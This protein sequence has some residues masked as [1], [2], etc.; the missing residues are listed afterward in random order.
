MINQY[1]AIKIVD[2]TP[3]RKRL[4]G[5]NRQR[6]LPGRT[7]GGNFMNESEIRKE[8]AI[9]K[10]VNHPN[11][12]R[13]KEII[14]DP[15]S[16]KLF[17]ILEYCEG[18]EVHWTE[19]DGSPALTLLETRRIF[20][21]TLL[22]LEYLH[23]QGI[24]HRDIKPSNLLWAADG[25]VKISDF[26][27]SHYSEALR[28]AATQAGPEGESWVDDVELAKTAGSPAFFAP[29]MCYSGSDQDDAA[30]HARSP[31]GTPVHELTNFTTQLPTANEQHPKTSRSDPAVLS[32]SSRRTFPFKPTQSNES[33]LSR[34]PQSMRSHSSSTIVHRDRMPIT[35]AIDVWALGVTLYCLAFGKTPFDAP[36]EYLLMQVIPT[37]DFHVPP[38]MSKDRLPTGKGNEDANEEALECLDLLRRLLEKDPARRISLDQAKR[39]P[40]TLRGLSDP[41][42]WLASTDPHVQSFVTVS[43][44]EVAAVVIKANRFRDRLRKGLKTISSRLS[45]FGSNSRGRSHSIGDG[46]TNSSY[47]QPVSNLP[48]AIPSQ[49]NLQNAND[50]GR[51]DQALTPRELSPMPSP[52]PMGSLSRRL[53]LLGSRHYDA[54]PS[55]RRRTLQLASP[56][57]TAHLSPTYAVEPIGRSLSSQSTQS[58]SRG[59]I[60]HRPIRNASQSNIRPDTV[61][62]HTASGERSA[63]SPKPMGSSGSLDKLQGTGELTPGDPLRR[64]Q[65]DIDVA[66]RHRS[67][68]N[69]S[70]NGLGLG[71]LAR[72]LSRGSSQRRRPTHTKESSEPSLQSTQG[73]GLPAIE[74]PPIMTLGE[75]GRQ[76][77]FET[78][79]SS[80]YSSG[81]GLSASPERS[82]MISAGPQRRRSTVSEVLT[83]S[84][85][86]DFDWAGSIPDD[87]DDDELEPASRSQSE[88]VTFGRR[89]VGGVSRPNDHVS[90]LVSS[91]PTLPTIQDSSPGS[92]L[93]QPL[94][95]VTSIQN[96]RNI[97]SPIFRSS[98]P[99]TNLVTRQFSSPST[100]R[101]TSAHER[102]RS[103]LG[104]TH[105]RRDESPTAGYSVF[106]SDDDDGNGDG[107]VDVGLAFSISAKRGRKGSVLDR[108]TAGA[109]PT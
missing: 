98:S 102:A 94:S 39:H 54:F 96:H 74:M 86:D 72:L 27:C 21:D 50:I 87:D 12:V 46:D 84:D 56:P 48:S 53:S 44:D 83:Q 75:H 97:T 89:F 41:S 38:Y 93:L 85:D 43:N 40:F 69:A 17:M 57:P 24:I 70:S 29:E 82:N 106:D 81:P 19:D 5:L 47:S 104:L 37:A 101:S 67:S 18:G 95:P 62:P 6:G 80:S 1:L 13:M 77:S 78:F 9:F 71:K 7:D 60:V 88:E 90:P 33:G 30:Q 64:R 36:N 79:E 34:R 10:K 15:E 76:S 8:I 55:P 16:S 68:S 4:T 2:R 109:A 23:H 52:R 25:T 65:S 92:L 108:H 49:I 32:P 73:T 28:T 11:V 66:A 22:G 63:D 107:D 3:K 103:P 14:D 105:H 58:S 100:P 45:I 35:N 42:G 31:Q 26:G 59:F 20:R 51:P 91:S 99:P 61:T